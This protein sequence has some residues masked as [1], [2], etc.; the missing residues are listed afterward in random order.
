MD[1]EIIVSII[2]IVTPFLFVLALIKTIIA[3]KE[4]KRE[5]KEKQE[6]FSEFDFSSEIV[7]LAKRIENLE[8]ILRSKE[9]Y[10]E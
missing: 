6:D 3:S 4:K 2:A 8:I 5:R 10:R 1:G 7:E 9:Q